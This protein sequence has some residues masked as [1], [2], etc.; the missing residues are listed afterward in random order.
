MSGGGYAGQP[1]EPGVLSEG[2]G[3]LRC[4]TED[5]KAAGH[6]VT[7]LLDGRISKLNPPLA[8]DFTVPVF[9]A[10]EAEKLLV[11]AAK[12]NDA[13]YVIAP[14][15]G[16]T[17]QSLIVLVEKTGKPTLNCE[18]QAIQR[19][20]DK[21]TLYETLK[22]KGLNTPETLNLNLDDDI[23]KIKNDIKNKLTY[24]VV[25]KPSDGV[26]CGGLSKIQNDSQIPTAIEKIRDASSQKT[27][28]AQEFIRGEAVSVSL[29]C[30]DG[31]ALAISLNKQNIQLAQPEE[32]SS[33]EGGAV[34][35]NHPLKAEAFKAAEK[36]GTSF[37]GL[38]GYV[39]V[40]L[41]LAEDKQFVID[42]NPRLTT[43][44]VGLRGVSGFNVAEALMEA[45][46]NTKLPKPQ[47]N[48][49]AVYFSKVKISKPSVSATQKAA[50]LDGV[51]SPPFPF[52]GNSAVSLVAGNGASM[53]D[54]KLRFEEAKK[55]LLNI[56]CRGK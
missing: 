25:F 46:L 40:D 3:M 27:F 15:T 56:V 1:L 24:P 43:S 30:T 55:R 19:V 48:K 23:A 35:F 37:S 54:A 5:F 6:E 47:E 10:K 18:A 7:V 22:S 2:Y 45:A 29:L 20:A 16:Q 42:V 36:V 33:Y 12:I 4:L 26:S 13:V 52:D 14:E 8:T 11:Y 21:S 28:V 9:Y 32:P 38:R 34:P 44:Y 50:Q 17:L 39:G 31:K 51:V 53:S 41:V 49:G